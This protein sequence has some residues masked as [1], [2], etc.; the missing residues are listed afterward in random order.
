M[1]EQNDKLAMWAV[2]NTDKPIKPRSISLFGTGHEAED[3]L[4]DFSYDSPSGYTAE[5]IG[6]VQMRNGLVWHLFDL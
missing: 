3:K 1:Q 2:V 4:T 5:H 6:T